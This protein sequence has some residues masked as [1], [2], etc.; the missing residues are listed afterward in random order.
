MRICDR[1]LCNG[2]GVCAE[3]CVAGA[4]VMHEDS[5]GFLYPRIDGKACKDCGACRRR[6]PANNDLVVVGRMKAKFYG[7]CAKSVDEVRS[8]TSGGLASVLA[9]IVVRKGGVVF[10]AA[11]DPFPKV[12][13]IGVEKESELVRFK[14]SKYVESNISDALP[15]VRFALAA[16]R[17]VLFIGLPCHVAAVRS[18][19][20]EGV[21]NLT[22]ID[23]VCHGKPA[24]RLFIHW[25]QQLEASRGHKVVAYRFRVKDDCSWNDARTHLHSCTFANGKEERISSRENWYSRYFLGSA[26]FRESCYCCQY[27]RLP[28][29]GD[30]TLADF[31]GA[32]NDARFANMIKH[33]VSLVSVQSENG[34]RLIAES[35]PSLNLVAVE[36][37]FA[38][39]SNRGLV[40]PSK[41]TI[42]RN[43][44]YAYIY[45]S[46][47]VAKLCDRILFGAGAIAK[48]FV[49]MLRGKR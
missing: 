21:E 20:G 37:A 40:C 6:C 8:S 3:V 28:R 16:K 32:E 27:A 35:R 38:L 43:F 13:H 1:V 18:F 45:R 33:G 17:P 49:K 36:K 39:N 2:C 30:I 26:S 23:L 48:R 5:S 10:G 24:Q 31:W 11:Y 12:R 19:I 9:R 22:T 46:P 29:V 41:R 7:G 44:I 34:D 47:C 42:Y 4:I 15:R 25:I 14:G